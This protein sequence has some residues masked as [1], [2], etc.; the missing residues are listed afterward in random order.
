ML[1]I[2]AAVVGFI[3]SCG[4][5]ARGD[6]TPK[7]TADSSTASPITEILAVMN[8]YRTL[9]HLDPLTES[10]SDSRDAAKHARYIVE[11]KLGPGDFT[12]DAGQVKREMSSTVHN[13]ERG[14]P[15][16]SIAGASVAS[17]S[18]VFTATAV[19]SDVQPLIDR[20]MTS[21]R[22]TMVVLEPTLVS[23]GYGDYC[24]DG[25]C[26]AVIAYNYDQSPARLASEFK[27]TAATVR[28]D[29][30]ADPE[31]NGSGDSVRTYLKSP[32]QFPPPDGTFPLGSYDGGREIDDPLSPCAGYKAP[33]GLP[34]VLSLGEGLNEA[35]AIK[36]D[37]YSLTEGDQPLESCGYD[38]F[39]YTNPKSEI[40]DAGRRLLRR[41]LTAVVI[42]R[43]PLKAG[44]TYSISMTADST[45]YK[46]S[47]KIEPD[48]R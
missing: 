41:T 5:N 15:Y 38:A 32:I 13:E 24:A 31:I 25:H 28:H 20:L 10:Q 23:L 2:V 22:S 43:A 4:S 30:L 33:T 17:R 36:L 27:L 40:Q 1:G 12:I 3:A 26:A 44:F 11:N 34:I 14:N 7:Q 45:E 47:F 42:P 39:S 29:V 16:Y 46:W 18:N 21:P 37:S 35:A 19:P 8:H 9:E 48:S 6:S